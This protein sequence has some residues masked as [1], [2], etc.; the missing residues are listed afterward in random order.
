MNKYERSEKFK[1]IDIV[2]KSSQ[3]SQPSYPPSPNHS[4]IPC[5]IPGQLVTLLSPP[6]R[7]KARAPL[8]HSC[9]APPHQYL[10]LAPI[11][12]KGEFEKLENLRSNEE[13]GMKDKDKDKDDL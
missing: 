4:H 8:L 13:R 11:S 5:L 1:K 2:P 9:T 6:D 3:Y 10:C 7:Y 12:P